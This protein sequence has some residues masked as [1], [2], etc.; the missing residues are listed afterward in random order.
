MPRPSLRTAFIGVVVALVGL[1]LAS[2]TL[3]ALPPN[4]YSDAVR[5]QTSYLDP[6]FTQNWRL[7][8][9]SPISEDRNLLVQA[10]YLDAGGRA[11][12]TAWIDWTAVELDLVR[13][14]LVGGR[15]GYVT[16]KLV[17]PLL[18]RS[19]ALD[20]SQRIVATSSPQADPLSWTELAEAL[21]AADT[22]ATVRIGYLRYDRT[23]TRLATDVL[24]ARYP[25]LELTAVRY[26]IRRQ[27]VVPYAA[28]DGSAAERRAARPPAV[29]DV[30]GWR[31]PTPGSPAEL[32]AVR[33]FDRRHR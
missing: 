31:R 4:R 6:Y 23:A 28:R 22:P 7:F 19:E 11:R 3:A 21:E 8:A 27:S 5:S 9:P 33:D 26:A 20:D 16:N 24:T 13:H 2:V 17:S 29:R 10:A 12:R 25:R 1:H 14:R 15:A 32:A 18:S 30:G